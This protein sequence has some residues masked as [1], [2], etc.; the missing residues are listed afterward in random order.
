[1]DLRPLFGRPGHYA[2]RLTLTHNVALLGGG[3]CYT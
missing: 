1:V 2:M 3:N